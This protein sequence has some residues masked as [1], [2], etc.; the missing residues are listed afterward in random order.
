M[1]K[2]KAMVS[3][4]CAA[5]LIVGSVINTAAV[6]AEECSYT[7]TLDN[8]EFTP[9]VETAEIDDSCLYYSILST[10][11]SYAKKYFGASDEDA[12]FSEENLVET[13]GEPD[14][15]NFGDIL[16]K[17]IGC[18]I[19]NGYTITSVE[20]LSGR[21][22]RYLKEKISE[23]GA[24]VAAIAVPDEDGLKNPQYYNESEHNFVYSGGD[25]DRYH[26]IS[27][28]GWDD[29]YNRNSFN[30]DSTGKSLG[31]KNGAWI[32]KNS[33]GTDFGDGGYFYMSY[34]TPLIYTA[35]LEVSQVSGVNI[36]L[37]PNQLLK[38]F[39]FI[40]GV[41]IRAFTS[42]TE[43][44]TVNIGDRTAFQGEVELKNGCNLILF[45][46]PV[47]SGKVSITGENISTS[48]DA[49]YC[50]W[51]LLPMKNKMTVKSAVK[52]EKWT[53]DVEAIWISVESS[54][55]YCLTKNP[56]INHI[57]RKNSND[58]CYYIIPADGY[59]FT[60]NTVIKKI[61]GFDNANL[62]IIYPDDYK[63]FRKNSTIAEAVEADYKRLKDGNFNF[64]K[65]IDF[66]PA[67][68][69]GRG[70]LKIVGQGIG[71]AYV[72]ELNILTDESGA[73]KN[74]ILTFDDG[75]TLT[76]APEISLFKDEEQTTKIEKI[77][78]LEE[79]YAEINISGYYA[80]QNSKLTVKINGVTSEVIENIS[81]IN[82][83]VKIDI[84]DVI[85]TLFEKLFSNETKNSK[86]DQLFYNIRRI[87]AALFA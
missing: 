78:N 57:V 45:E 58:N 84:P 63:A 2:I 13:A 85:L 32:C 69:G 17:S 83:S 77:D 66:D 14:I 59:R 8:R 15:H 7:K 49:V 34:T 39:G 56:A 22:E 20:L 1:K 18:N 12:D 71:S 11:G 35:A 40:Y 43:E 72:N 10:A 6:P 51:S 33:Y 16:Y 31:K 24:I 75:S 62:K 70:M 54:G 26:A 67:Y 23:N 60:E 65:M 4:L 73:I 76:V 41:N 47:L 36:I 38:Y 80:D 19:G 5:A 28:V 30:K 74:T 79:Y 81:E 82:V 42:A 87:F 27:I 86:L 64:K 48:N 37:N 55:A 3:M 21:G 68:D 25:K 9:P 46:H 29:D 52:D 44:I 50:Y 61:D 53:E